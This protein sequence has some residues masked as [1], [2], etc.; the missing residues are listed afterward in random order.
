MTQDLTCEV[1]M[2]GMIPT[3][4]LRV[5]TTQSG[6]QVGIMEKYTITTLLNSFD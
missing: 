4:V 5:M 3:Q 2:V 1:Y 6:Q